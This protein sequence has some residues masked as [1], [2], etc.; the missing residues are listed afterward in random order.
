[1]GSS[2]YFVFYYVVM[3]FLPILIL[4]DIISSFLNALLLFR[5]MLILISIDLFVFSVLSILEIFFRAEKL[6]LNSLKHVRADFEKAQKNITQVKV[7]RFIAQNNSIVETTY[8]IKANRFTTVLDAL[9]EIKHKQ[10][11]TL[12]VRYSCRMG[13]CGSCGVVING[14]PSLACESNLLNNSKN[15]EILVEP[16]RGQPILKD[17][18]ADFD[19]FFEKHKSIG[20][21]LYRKNNKEKIT[22]K[23]IY[24]QT[25]EEMNRFLP[26]SF[27]IMCGLCLDACPV[28]N[29]NKEFLGPQALSQQYRYYED[30]RDESKTKR[31]SVIDSLS[32][33]WGCEFAGSCSKACPKGVDPASAIQ[34]L[35]IEV[36]KKY[37][38]IN[39]E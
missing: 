20:P 21:T 17:L 9:L 18:V 34:L 4:I 3:G 19:D 11:P 36:A 31:L 24:E 37:I 2:R 29:T 7:G 35:K 22:A 5:L 39:Y 30:T 8:K 16:I 32:G 14:K 27:C 1:M 38:D 28:V 26:Y 23:S 15:E 6:Q 25:T 33:V 10:D 12:T 13:I